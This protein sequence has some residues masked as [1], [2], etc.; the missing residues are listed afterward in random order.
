MSESRQ[1]GYIAVARGTLSHKAFRDKAQCYAWLWLLMEAAWRADCRRGVQL[2]RGQLIASVRSLGKTWGW[3][4]GR[5][6]R[7]LQK[8]KK[9]GMIKVTKIT[10]GAQGVTISETISGTLGRGTMSVITICNYDK[11]QRGGKAK[12]PGTTRRAKQ[13]PE[14]L[15]LEALV[16]ESYSVDQEGKKD[17][18]KNKPFAREENR[19][20]SQWIWVDYGTTEWRAYAADFESVRGYA[21]LP[22]MRNGQHGRFFVRLGEAHRPPEKRRG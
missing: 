2:S 3:T 13:Q 15:S 6:Y 5:V 14:Q 19:G 20:S 8:L 7:F 12:I 11:F 4:S 18:H 9:E 1:F 10:R 16:L 17:N 22:K 21:I